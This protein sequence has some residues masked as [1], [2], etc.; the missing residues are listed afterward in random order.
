MQIPEQLADNIRL[1]RDSGRFFRDADEMFAL[2]S[3]VQ[4]MMGQHFVPQGYHP[5]VDLIPEQELHELASSIRNVVANCVA[6]MP[7]HEQFIARYCQAV[8]A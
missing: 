7:M 3:W 4:V 6:A 5:A 8:A 2:T 1:F